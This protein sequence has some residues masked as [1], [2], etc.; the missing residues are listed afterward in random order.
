LLK[1][2]KSFTSKQT[3]SSILSA[4]SKPCWKK[5]TKTKS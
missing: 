2:P 1:D 5:R 4:S 3:G